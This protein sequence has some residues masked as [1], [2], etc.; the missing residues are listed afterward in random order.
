MNMLSSFIPQ[1]ILGI[2][3]GFEDIEVNMMNKNRYKRKEIYP[4]ASE[5]G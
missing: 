2:L 4:K 3:L 5:T 1:K